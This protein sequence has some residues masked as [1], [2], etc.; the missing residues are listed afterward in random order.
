MPAILILLLLSAFAFPGA[1]VAEDAVHPALLSKFTANVGR[2]Y[3]DRKTK[4]TAGAGIED[5]GVDFQR[6]LDIDIEGDVFSVDFNW[7]FGEKWSL[8]GQYFNVSGEKSAELTRDISWNDVIFRAGTTVDA[9]TGFKLYRLFVG[10]SF[11]DNERTEYGIGA[12]I[13]RLQTR[14]EIA[15]SVFIDDNQ[16]FTRE[17][18]KA[19]GPLPNIG[20]WYQHSL[21]PR[22]ALKARA[23]WFSANIDDYD[24]RL[25]NIQA[26]IDYRIFRHGGIGLAY[27]YFEFDAGVKN[28]TWRG[29]ADLNYKGLFAHLALYW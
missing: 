22:W 16:A 15:G 14:A 2:F 7:R 3:P 4:L 28:S 21:T 26:G 10:R 12:G 11:S 9:S 6:D 19:K 27:N 20:A 5:R 8:A 29:K 25:I 17:S 24:G 18:V 1:A 13:H 23:D